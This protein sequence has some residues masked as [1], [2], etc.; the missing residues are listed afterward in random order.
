MSA[1]RT[2]GV[3]AAVAGVVLAAVLVERGDDPEPP[4][5]APVRTPTATPTATTG[6][7]PLLAGAVVVLDPGHNGGNARHLVE[8]RR[9]VDAGGFLKDCNT[10]GTAAGGVTESA[11]NWQLAQLVAAGL[12]ARGARVELTRTDDEGWGPCV[13]ERAALATRWGADLL[14]S[15]HADGAPSGEHGFHVIRPGELPGYTDDIVEESAALAS[16]VKEG[17]V[18]AGL[19]PATYRGRD[20]V[21]VRTDLGTLN[22]ADVPAVLVEC[23]NLRHPGDLTL[24]TTPEGREQVAQGLV[25]GVVR[26]LS[27]RQPDVARPRAGDG[28]SSRTPRPR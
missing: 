7:A 23:G 18:A 21:D 1:G 22:R 13:D 25:A 20:G 14:L 26:H 2:A 6:G 27:S 12:R 3:A 5:P 15:L 4:V 11:V 17:L 24:L 10:T 9:Q 19:T 8:I 28:F 16:T